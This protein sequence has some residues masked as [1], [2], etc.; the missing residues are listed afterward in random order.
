MRVINICYVEALQQNQEALEQ[1]L[2]GIGN[3]V[4]SDLFA[5]DIKQALNYWVRLPERI[6][7]PKRVRF[8]YH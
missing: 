5:M 2:Y 7:Y 8:V 6:R 1:V 3:L 4:T